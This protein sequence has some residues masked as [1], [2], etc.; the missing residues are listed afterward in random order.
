MKHLTSF[1]LFKIRL[2]G[3][4]YAM[5]YFT[6]HRRFLGPRLSTW[7]KWGPLILALVSWVGRWPV[8]WVFLGLIW[9]LVAQIFYWYAKRKG[10]IRFLPAA[11]NS[12]HHSGGSLSNNQKVNTLATG[13]FSVSSHAAYVLL[14][15]AEYWQVPVGDHAIMVQ[16]Q[17]GKYLYQFIQPGALRSVKAG[18]LVFGR[19]PREALAISFL[20][21]WGPEF[22]QNAPQQFSP[23][24]NHTPARLEQTI[25][26]TFQDIDDCR[27]VHNNLL[28]DMG[29][30]LHKPG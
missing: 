14:Q 13:T 9:F 29:K 8:Y 30:P 16:H 10:Y 26:L 11:D 28:Q 5:A 6:V 20:T 22:G 19:R 12:Q 24:S 7:L 2:T 23:G 18:Y 15:P 4:L 27:L 3:V 25:Y 21:T 1:E 17:P